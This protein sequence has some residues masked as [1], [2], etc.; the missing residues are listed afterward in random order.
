MIKK[1][2]A[3]HRKKFEA[4]GGWLSLFEDK[5]VFEPH[6]FNIQK[7][8]IVINLKDVENITKRWNKL[9]GLIPVVPN[10]IEISLMNGEKQKFMVYNRGD[11]IQKILDTKSK[12]EKDGRII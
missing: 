4:V 9:F 3:S 12:L 6:S 8:K 7:E 2:H 5:I 10:I 1:G 11:W